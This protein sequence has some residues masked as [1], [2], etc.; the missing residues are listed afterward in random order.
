MIGFRAGSN[1]GLLLATS[2]DEK[3][4]G[5]PNGRHRRTASKPIRI[6]TKGYS[7]SVEEEVGASG[8]STRSAA[9]RARRQERRR[10]ILLIVAATMATLTVAGSASALVFYRKLNGNLTVERI[11]AKLS[12][13]RPRAGSANAAG[14][15]PLNVL[16]IGSDTREGQNGFG[17]EPGQRADV[18]LA[19]HLS[20]NRNR[21]EIISFPRD[22]IVQIP[23]CVRNDGTPSQP[24]IGL[25]NSAFAIGGTACVQ[26]T[27]ESLTGVRID[28][29]VVADF[30]GFQGMVDAIGGVEVCLPK[31]VHDKD[32]KL[33]LPAGRQLVRGDQA[34]AFAR[35]RHGIGDGSDTQR[36]ERQKALMGAIVTKVKSSGVL[37][38]P[39][40]L[41]GLLNAATKSLTTDPELASVKKLAA[42]AQSVKGMPAEAITFVTVPTMPDPE[43]PNRVRWVQPDADAL[44]QSIR[45][46]QPFG[47][48]PDAAPQAPTLSP[49]AVRVDVLNGTGVDGQAHGIADE[50]IGLGFTVTDVRNA[51]SHNYSTT[52]VTYPSGE[53]EAARTL[54]SVIP[55]VTAVPG[56]SSAGRVALIIGSNFPGIPQTG[57]SASTL[58]TTPAAFP[59]PPTRT[60]AQDSCS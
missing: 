40:T 49:A 52:I 50:L 54:A 28:H 10:K 55:G 23:E 36:I 51:D 32:S 60:A 41:Y 38:N 9:R 57:Q 37:L 26:N 39:A 33:E 44:F 47:K 17:N 19:V 8:R 12:R 59:A 2:D 15:R 53:Q 7:A 13:D 43:N 29:H 3:G 56:S 22:A 27:V 21:A 4:D 45:E 5:D 16:A 42:L 18:T 20:A 30:Q 1:T 58:K 48:S 11:A 35:T 34:L 14:Q 24:H 25:F 31:A 46:D 6:Q